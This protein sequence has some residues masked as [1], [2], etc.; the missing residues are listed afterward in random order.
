VDAGIVKTIRPGT[1]FGIVAALAAICLLATEHLTHVA[2]FVP[3]AL[4]L[5]CP[6]M[7][8]FGGHGRHGHD[9]PHDSDGHP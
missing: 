5:A 1:L 8:L 4:I 6:L 2:R 7:H 9:H 3:Y